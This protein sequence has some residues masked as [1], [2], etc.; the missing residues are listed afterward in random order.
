MLSEYSVHLTQNKAPIDFLLIDIDTDIY[1]SIM[2]TWERINCQWSVITN[3]LLVYKDFPG[4]FQYKD[5]FIRYEDFHHKD[6]TESR[7][8]YLYHGNPCIGKMKM[9]PGSNLPTSL[10]LGCLVATPYIRSF[11]NQTA[12]GFDSKDWGKEC[13][14]P[15]FRVACTVWG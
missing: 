2:I 1:T 7:P 15:Q 10:G 12:V 11:W 8:S 6:K 3:L 5:C 4:L 14:S 13:V 9:F